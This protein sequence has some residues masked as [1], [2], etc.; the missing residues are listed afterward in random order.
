V[1]AADGTTVLAQDIWA[2]LQQWP[3]LG[4]QKPGCGFSV[5]CLVG[6]FCLASGAPLRATH[7]PRSWH[8]SRLFAFLRRWMRKGDILVADRGFWSYLNFS[9][10]PSRGV[11]LIV[12]TKDA[13]KIDW[14]RG[15]RL[16]VDDRLVTRR[17]PREIS[18]VVGSRCWNRLAPNIEV[19]QIQTREA[20]GFP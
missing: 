3:Q 4:S 17:K 15:R 7:G 13:A 5:I 10:L 16:G 6:I 2:N 9:L 1:L 19:R 20:Q 14:R 18:T 11:H 12:R 8:E